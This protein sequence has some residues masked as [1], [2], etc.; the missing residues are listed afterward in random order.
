MPASPLRFVVS[1]TVV[2]GRINEV[3]AIIAAIETLAA[4]IPVSSFRNAF[5]GAGD[6]G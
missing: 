1:F 4:R 6:S 5:S 3:K 2:P